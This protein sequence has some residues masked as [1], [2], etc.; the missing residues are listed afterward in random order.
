MN[1][2]AVA[3]AGC[4]DSRDR[5]LKF[6]VHDQRLTEEKKSR[7]VRFSLV[8]TGDQF[9]GVD[10]YI[11]LILHTYKIIF[12]LRAGFCSMQLMY[13]Y[14]LKRWLPTSRPSFP[15]IPVFSCQP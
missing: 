4:G 13:R 8:R 14:L 1:E 3:V 7:S 15:K 6:C 5:E 2:V 9:F 10:P 12:Y 11:H